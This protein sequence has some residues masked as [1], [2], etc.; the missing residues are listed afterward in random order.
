MDAKTKQALTV[1]GTIL[2]FLATVGF[3][4]WL[5]SIENRLGKLDGSPG[6][7][8]AKI[9]AAIQKATNALS[10]K[11]NTA[12]TEV[13]NDIGKQISQLENQL[14]DRINKVDTALAE[15]N[16]RIGALQIAT[17]RMLAKINDEL[18]PELN[19]R[20]EQEGGR[21]INPIQLPENV[22]NT[23]ALMASTQD[24]H[25]HAAVIWRKIYRPQEFPDPAAAYELLQKDPGEFLKKYGGLPAVQAQS[26]ELENLVKKKRDVEQ[27]H[28]TLEYRPDR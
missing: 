14:R 3:F 2:M 24:Y 16:K 22:L 13:G 7:V 25:S 27:Q 20:L 19:R 6:N 15:S 11:V 4:G 28:R 10:E 21:R 17:G 12:K 23:L 18:I 9:D 1:I 8:D 26:Q 5:L